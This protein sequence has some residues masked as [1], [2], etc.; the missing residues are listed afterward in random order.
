L[1]K[2]R[3]IS[4]I[5][6]SEMFF[7]VLKTLIDPKEYNVSYHIKPIEGLITEFRSLPPPDL[8]LVDYCLPRISGLELIA[9]LRIELEKHLESTRFGLLTS[10]PFSEKEKAMIEESGIHLIEKGLQL[11][12]IVDKIKKFLS[13]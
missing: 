10:Y 5:D 12:L 2:Q 1:K 13:P 9:R 7:V 6:D 8:I 4:V 11:S 3:N